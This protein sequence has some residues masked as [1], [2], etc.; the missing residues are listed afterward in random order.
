MWKVVPVDSVLNFASSTIVEIISTIVMAN[1]DWKH[2]NLM[3]TLPTSFLFIFQMFNSTNSY[4]DLSTE[5]KNQRIQEK[6]TTLN[7]LANLQSDSSSSSSDDD[8]IVD[9]TNQDEP[10]HFDYHQYIIVWALMTIW[11]VRPVIFLSLFLSLSV[12]FEC[13]YSICFFLEIFYSIHV[14]E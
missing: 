3:L 11:H 5:Q 1:R 2:S 10:S 7:I 14:C 13:F 4:C 12:F 9:D 8:P 6:I